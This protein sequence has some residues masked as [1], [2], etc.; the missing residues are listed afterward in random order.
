M[1]G[2]R[3]VDLE[4]CSTPNQ[5][6]E[7]ALSIANKPCNI[8]ATS[9]IF[10]TSTMSMDDALDMYLKADVKE[11]KRPVMDSDATST[12][13]HKTINIHHK[14]LGEIQVLRKRNG[15]LRSGHH[16]MKW[17]TQ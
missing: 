13:L 14:T 7:L 11:I 5:I 3:G 10:A 2:E 17:Y 9:K 15:S 16:V 4:E 12:K 1:S 8:I 6:R